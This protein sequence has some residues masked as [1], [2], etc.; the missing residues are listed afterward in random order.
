MRFIFVKQGCL[1]CIEF[2]Q[3]IPSINMRL[4]IGK[5]IRIIDNTNF[6]RYGI[7]TN[8]IQTKLDE[9]DFEDYPVLYLD[10]ILYSGVAW[11][12]QVKIML[13]RYL[14]KDFRKIN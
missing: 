1:V 8:F 11:A 2:K 10:G 5:Q 7:V 4:P 13:E 6:E 9:K 3:V 12:K 14:Q